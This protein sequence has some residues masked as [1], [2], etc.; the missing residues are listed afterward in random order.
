MNSKLTELCSQRAVQAEHHELN[1]Y[2]GDGKDQN[3]PRDAMTWG[4]E[5]REYRNEKDKKPWL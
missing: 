3:L 2:A 5:L 1:R 4:D